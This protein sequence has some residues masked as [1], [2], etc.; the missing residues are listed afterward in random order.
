[1][2][3]VFPNFTMSKNKIKNRLKQWGIPNITPLNGI[4]EETQMEKIA[5]IDK[6]L[7]ASM[8][9]AY[10]A[11]ISLAGYEEMKGTE[12]FLAWKSQWVQQFVSEVHSKEP[13]WEVADFIVHWTTSRMTSSLRMTVETERQNELLIGIYND[14]PLKDLVDLFQVPLP[15][16]T[17]QN[18]GFSVSQEPILR[19]KIE[20]V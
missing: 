4:T 12:Q 14:R 19:L 2:Y 16:I 8:E 20:E 17:F 11:E 10:R 13:F 1:M 7:T 18:P 15:S 3:L 5:R 6:S 9:F